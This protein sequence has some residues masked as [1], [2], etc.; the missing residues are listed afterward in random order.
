MY[1]K[2][3]SLET[4]WS[5]ADLYKVVHIDFWWWKKNDLNLKLKVNERYVFEQQ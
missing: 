4:P 2:K 1:R 3:K 5:I